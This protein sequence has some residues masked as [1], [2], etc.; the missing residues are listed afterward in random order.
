MRLVLLLLAGCLALASSESIQHDELRHRVIR[1]GNGLYFKGKPFRFV[2]YNVPSL[3]LTGD[4]GDNFVLPDTFDIEDLIDTLAGQVNPVGRT[5]PLGI[6][7][8]LNSNSVYHISGCRE[9]NE[10][11]FATMDYVLAY[12]A[13]RKVKL[14]VPLV[15]N[16]WYDDEGN[17]KNDWFGNWGDFA[18]LC[19]GNRSWSTFYED[20]GVRLAF[21][22]FITSFLNRINTVNGIRYG[23]DPTIMAL[24]TGNELG[25]WEDKPPSAD[26]TIDIAGHVKSLAPH[27]LVADGT[28]FGEN[29]D[30]IEPSVKASQFVDMFSNHFY[31]GAKVDLKR[32]NKD[33][34]ALAPY[35]KVYWCGEFGLYTKLDNYQT[36][37]DATLDSVS[38]GILIWSLRGH[39]SA[40]GFYTHSENGGQWESLHVPGWAERPPGFGP[41]AETLV[42]LLFEYAAKIA[43]RN[44]PG[45]PSPRKAP[46]I[47]D[48]ES[49]GDLRWQG[50]AWADHYQVQRAP[51]NRGRNSKRWT[52]VGDNV[53]DNVPSGEAIFSDP[54]P[55][56]DDDPDAQFFYRVRAVSRRGR[57]SRYSRPYGPIPAP[58]KVVG[59]LS[60]KLT[61][62]IASAFDQTK[63]LFH[64]R[65]A[66]DSTISTEPDQYLLS[67]SSLY[68]D[69]WTLRNIWSQQCIYDGGKTKPQNSD[70]PRFNLP[71][72]QRY[73][74]SGT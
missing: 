58:K 54:V 40:G 10:D 39:S 43:G 72:V 16:E 32:M 1:S 13:K 18:Y 11:A 63:Y 8:T 26:W 21:K 42:P 68:P 27:L 17:P 52:T 33:I 22:G 49:G 28:M 12:A 2:S 37:L 24:E 66:Y 38:A 20:Q 73:A 34:Q 70:S 46:T 25:A 9:Y 69:Q 5:M 29:P 44:T 48:T 50:V 19:G 7:S 3:L 60:R 56:P 57:K 59:D 65:E 45:Y 36:V 14:V 31:F 6:K 51:A 64:D 67:V 23:N 74:Y 61:T 53:I 15:N 30:R 35:N 41:E 71:F 47:L 62:S 55:A 4:K